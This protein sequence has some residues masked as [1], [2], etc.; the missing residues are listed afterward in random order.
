[1]QEPEGRSYNEGYPESAGYPPYQ[2]DEQAGS[3]RPQYESQQKLQ[4]ESEAKLSTTNSVL[5]ILSVVASSLIMGLSIALVA[6]TANIFGRIIGA[7]VTDML[8]NSVFG[9]IIA[10]FVI[11]LVLLLFSIVGFVF[12]TIQLSIMVKKLKRVRGAAKSR[13]G[14]Q[15]RPNN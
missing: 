10:S 7:G 4:P 11:S 8:P 13:P 15:N 9:I 6:L 12:S 14:Y 5:A 2:D 1:M 3:S